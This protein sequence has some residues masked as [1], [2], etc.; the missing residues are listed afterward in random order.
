MIK[1]ISIGARSF[2]INAARSA[3]LIKLMISEYIYHSLEVDDHYLNGGFP[4]TISQYE[5]P[6]S[7]YCQALETLG[8]VFLHRA[9]SFRVAVG[10]HQLALCTSLG[11]D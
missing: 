9:V 11:Y 1:N 7:T 2:S 4:T 5:R 8:Q 6:F 10:A 3:Q